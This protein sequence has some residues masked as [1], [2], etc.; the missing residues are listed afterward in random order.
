METQELLKG[1]YPVLKI[2]NE[3]CLLDVFN[4]G[5]VIFNNETELNDYVEENSKK[6]SFHHNQSNNTGK[7]IFSMTS[8]CSLA[9]PYCY[10]RGGERK[11]YLDPIVSNK[12]IDWFLDKGVRNIVIQ[13]FGGEPTLNKDTIKH[14]IDYAEEKGLAVKYELSTNGLIS[15]KDFCEY[16]LS[17]ENITWIISLDGTKEIHDKQRPIRKSFSETSSYDNA[18][19]IIKKVLERERRIKIRTTVTSIN[20]SVLPQIIEHFAS[21]GIKLI[22]LEVFNP[23]GRGKYV[24]WLPDANEYIDQFLKSVEVAEKLDVKVTQFGLFDLFN[25]SDLMCASQYKY[26]VVVMP[27]NRDLLFCLGAQEEFGEIVK[28]LT[29][30]HISNGNVELDEGKMKALPL[31][32]SVNDIDT[33]KDCFIKYVCKG[34][35]PAL[36]GVRNGDW[37]APDLYS[38]QIRNGIIKGLMLKLYNNVK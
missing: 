29:I 17:N 13:F 7:I 19:E 31:N 12:V 38:C 6:F 30:G 21:I 14:I 10:V 20:V 35:C 22:H 33:C 25:P 26:R 4:E 15:D 24:K 3:Y 37:R 36:N 23:L 1:G 27:N 18:V 28:L 8:D 34:I 9:C 11:E 2:E 16:L 32:F 5:L